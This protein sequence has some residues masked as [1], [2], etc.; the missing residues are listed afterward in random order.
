MKDN[1]KKDSSTEQIVLNTEIARN[2]IIPTGMCFAIEQYNF[3]IN[4]Y[5]LVKCGKMW[6]V[7]YFG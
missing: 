2:A 3:K 7:I 1:M 4:T 5:E 6:V